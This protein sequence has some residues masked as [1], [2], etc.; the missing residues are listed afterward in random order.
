MPLF[1]RKHSACSLPLMPLTAPCANAGIHAANKPQHKPKHRL[2]K[3]KRVARGGLERAP[4][5]RTRCLG[6]LSEYSTEPNPC[7]LPSFISPRN[8]LP[9]C[10]CFCCVL[11]FSCR[12][13]ERSVSVR[14]R[15]CVHETRVCASYVACECEACAAA[16]HQQAA[17]TAKFSVLLKLTFAVRLCQSLEL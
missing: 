5:K 12:R 4:A 6:S 16:Q 2:R 10:S 11:L 8:T 7:G 17:A 1:R 15:L 9:S 14:W 13:G 3:Q